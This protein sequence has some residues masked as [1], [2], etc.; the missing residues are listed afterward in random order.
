[1]LTARL[2]EYYLARETPSFRESLLSLYTE[3]RVALEQAMRQARFDST[4]LE[5]GDLSKAAQ[6]YLY[7]A[8]YGNNFQSEKRVWEDYLCPLVALVLAHCPNLVRL[9]LH[10]GIRDAFLARILHFAIERRATAE[11]VPGIAFQKLEKLYVSPSN[12]LDRYAGQLRV[13]P[14]SQTSLDRYRRYHHLPRLKEFVILNGSISEGAI[15][16]PTPFE[17]LALPRINNF[18]PQIEPLFRM[19][20]GL[21]HLSFSSR[22]Q[23][24]P[25]F[26]RSFWPTLNHLKDTLEYLDFY[27]EH[28]DHMPGQKKYFPDL[29]ELSFCPPLAEFTKLRYLATT[30]LLLLGHRCKHETPDKL[31]SHLPPN[32][33]SLGFYTYRTDWLA[34]HIPYFEIELEAIVLDAIPRRKLSSICLDFDNRLPL[35]KMRHAATEHGITFR[36]DGS[37]CMLYAGRESPF[38]EASRGGITISAL[39]ETLLSRKTAEIIPRC[40]TVQSVK[41]KLDIA[42]SFAPKRKREIALLKN[43]QFGGASKR[44]RPS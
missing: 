34:S 39:A 35:G 25:Q 20:S 41:G 1:M 43:A 7:F 32:L 2:A 17:Q 13:I 15:K 44:A 14:Y 21:R 29:Q 22:Y 31:R 6:H 40:M 12:C 28:Y 27:E 42:H 33:E 10:T 18:L 23:K 38:A 37:S 8:L 5:G 9:S 30:P 36:T 4:A 19:S 24:G 16:R 11:Q 3:N 26:H